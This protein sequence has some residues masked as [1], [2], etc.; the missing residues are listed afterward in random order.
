MCVPDCNIIFLFT[1]RWSRNCG[2]SERRGPTKKTY[3]LVS[4]S[5]QTCYIVR[6]F[7]FFLHKY[8]SYVVQ[9][10]PHH[11]PTSLPPAECRWPES[12]CHILGIHHVLRENGACSG[13]QMPFTI[14]AYRDV[15]SGEEPNSSRFLKITRGSLS[16]CLRVLH[17]DVYFHTLLIH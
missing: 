5:L 9:Y 14:Y 12:P 1:F 15:P 13:C 2:N 17:V 4:E 3:T 16:V 10:I 6:L 8:L 11:H 7:N